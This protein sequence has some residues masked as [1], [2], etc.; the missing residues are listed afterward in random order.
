MIILYILDNCPNC[1]TMKNKLKAAG[2]EFEERDMASAESLAQLRYLGCFA[3]TAP[4]LRIEDDCFEY[5]QC[6]KENFFCELFGVCKDEVHI[7]EVDG[8]MRSL[9]E[10]AGEP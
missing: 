9:W 1:K 8:R 5:H 2:Y 10:K 7:P 3:V 4:V 6:M